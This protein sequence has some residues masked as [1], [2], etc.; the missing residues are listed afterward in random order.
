[1]GITFPATQLPDDQFSS[2]VSAVVEEQSDL[3][4]DNFVK[5][6][7]TL[8]WKEAHNVH[9]QLFY[10]DLQYTKDIWA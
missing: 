4:W 6:R 3:Q 9:I 10:P 5:D 7:V 2:I 8:F 1:M